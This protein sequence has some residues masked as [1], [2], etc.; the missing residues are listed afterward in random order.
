MH[1][2][3][4]GV[5]PADQF[6]GAA[7]RLQGFAAARLT[8]LFYEAETV[9][10]EF[11]KKYSVYADRFPQWS[12]HSSGMAQINVWTA[13]ANE[14]LGCNLQHYGNL[15]EGK[16]ASKWGLPKDWRLKAE[17]V[18]GEKAG[19]AGEKS[20]MDDAERFKVFGGAN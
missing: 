7:K 15:T 10:Q 6:E 20:F 18:V 17:L 11:Q 9:V 16:I 1:D 3:V 13:L 19:E 8:I 12:E 4:K 14:G 5:S 2:A